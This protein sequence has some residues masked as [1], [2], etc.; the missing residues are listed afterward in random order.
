MNT[1]GLEEFQK[2]ANCLKQ[3]LLKHINQKQNARFKPCVS[4][5]SF[6]TKINTIEKTY[7]SQAFAAVARFVKCESVRGAFDVTWNIKF[8]SYS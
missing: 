4:P 5:L 2:R 7:W 1:R 3:C 8:T 6:L